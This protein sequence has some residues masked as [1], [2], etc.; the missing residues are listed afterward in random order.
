LSVDLSILNLVVGAS[1][2]VKVVIA[3]LLFA[4]LASWTLIVIKWAVLG[5]AYRSADDFEES[6]W[7]G[8]DLEQLYEGI[9]R[10]TTSN[11]LKAVFASGFKEYLRQSKTRGRDYF[12]QMDMITRS[13]RVTMTRE[14]DKLERSLSFLATV[15]STSTYIG[16]FGTVWGIMNSFRALGDAQLNTL[17]AVAPGIA[18]ALI[19][20]AIGLFAAIPAV[21]A[22]NRFSDDVERLI[23]RYDNFVEEFTTLLQRHSEKPTTSPS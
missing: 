22:Y 16:L 4:S 14:V 17:S 5:K 10:D 15:G 19:A 23:T 12:G 13:M 2:V 8:T 11:G 9:A 7:S 6:F 18:E 3:I 21:I 1:L 20:T